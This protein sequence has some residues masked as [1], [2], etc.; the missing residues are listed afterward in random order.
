M[1]V[2]IEFKDQFEDEWL[3]SGR[4]VDDDTFALTKSGFYRKK[5]IMQQYFWFADG[6]RC[7]RRDATI[8]T[9]EN[10]STGQPYTGFGRDGDW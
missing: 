7:G 8:S 3:R 5:T 10:I 9:D 6:Y 2:F 4:D 1:S